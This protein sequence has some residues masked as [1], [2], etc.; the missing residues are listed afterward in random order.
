MTSGGFTSV[1]GN[2]TPLYH[3]VNDHQCSLFT[4]A[5]HTL[6]PILQIKSASE[7]IEFNHQGKQYCYVS[8][9]FSIYY[10]C[11]FGNDLYYGT[12]FS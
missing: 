6:Y 2:V 8:A 11:F 10:V 1:A 12:V 9:C 3:I 5:C 7:L 4:K